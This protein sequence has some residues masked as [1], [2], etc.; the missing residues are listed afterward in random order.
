VSSSFFIRG[1]NKFNKAET[2]RITRQ[3]DV[4]W[5]AAGLAIAATVLSVLGI[6]FPVAWW[7]SPLDYLNAFNL[8]PL[9]GF[10]ISASIL[11]LA[12]LLILQ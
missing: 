8:H 10:D 5:L 6:I 2:S 4:L 1:T 7:R 11:L 9:I 3:L 12:T